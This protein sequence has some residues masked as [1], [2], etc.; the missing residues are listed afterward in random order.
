MQMIFEEY[1][2]I[3][4][5]SSDSVWSWYRDGLQQRG[6]RVC[7]VAHY[8]IPRFAA[9]C[10]VCAATVTHAGI[11]CQFD[12]STLPNHAHLQAAD[13]S[14]ERTHEF[15]DPAIYRAS[16]EQTPHLRRTQP[17]KATTSYPAASAQLSQQLAVV[18]CKHEPWPD[19]D[20]IAPSP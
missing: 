17:L 13:R 15:Y 8:M 2:D 20:K 5:Y 18:P 19:Y 7:G 9:Y 4:T 16:Q 11:R 1:I 14:R 10:N 3:K 6:G 12:Y